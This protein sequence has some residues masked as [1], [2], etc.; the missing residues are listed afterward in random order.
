MPL[1]IEP[2]TVHVDDDYPLQDEA[3]A[4][5]WRMEQRH[6][7]HRARNRWILRT[8]ERS[9][10]RPGARFLE[11][12]CG[13]GTVAGA[14]HGEGYHVTGVDTSEIQVRQAHERFPSVDFLVGD[15]MTLDAA[16]F[17]PFDGVGF[18]DVLEH[19][20][21]PGAMLS[22]AARLAAPGAL[23]IATVPAQRAL[24]T[25]IDSLS[26]HKR[27]YEAGELAAIMQGCGLERVE[28]FASFA[29]QHPFSG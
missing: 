26:G 28:E 3:L 8:L 20:D 19:L 6:F 23:V 7:W 22:A 29:R 9:G 13:S 5:L 24:H 17:E 15:V 2:G 1:H 25:I 11:V 18:F 4:A 16:A 21:D 10:L 27:R 14:L 12:G